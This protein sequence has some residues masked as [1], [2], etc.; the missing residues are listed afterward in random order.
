MR[1]VGK[2]EINMK[3]ILAIALL[4]VSGFALAHSGGTNSSGCHTNNKT[5][6]YHCH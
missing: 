5:G 6:D 3:K 2:I 4:M 1:T